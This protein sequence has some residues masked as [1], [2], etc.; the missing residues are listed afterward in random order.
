M[1][2]EL[3]EMF[4]YF[5]GKYLGRTR[6]FE[7][8]IP[9]AGLCAGRLWAEKVS[10]GQEAKGLDMVNSSCKCI[11][12]GMV[13][14]FSRGL[15]VST[16][17]R[18]VIWPLCCFQEHLFRDRVQAGPP[19]NRLPIDC[20]NRHCR[21]RSCHGE[22]GV[23]KYVR[24]PIADSSSL[25]RA[26]SEPLSSVRGFLRAGG[27]SHRRGTSISLKAAGCLA[28]ADRLPE[29]ARRKRLSFLCTFAPPCCLFAR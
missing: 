8:R 4:H 27:L 26:I 9:V 12:Q 11:T 3:S 13:K 29:C 18:P 19:W 20:R 5:E 25:N 16:F 17:S 7:R 1:Q 10:S 24:R 15:V 28:H 22:R 6:R 2:A 23:H 21:S 14:N